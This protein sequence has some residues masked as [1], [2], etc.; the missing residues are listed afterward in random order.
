M[1][2]RWWM[3]VGLLCVGL[4]GCRKESPTAEAKDEHSEEKEA[5]VTVGVEAARRGNVVETVEGLGRSEAIPSKLAML[6]PAVEGHVHE[7]V[8]KQGETVKKGQPIVEF[9]QSAAL[10]DLAEK[11]ATRDGLKASLALL[12]VVPRPEERRSNELAVEQ[13]KVALE[14]AKAALER[15]RPL[16]T[17]REVSE[18]QVFEAELAVTSAQ[19]LEKT[20]E[21][22][23]H[24]MLIGPKP[25]AVAEA[26]AKI[27]VADGA[28]AFSKAHL[29]FHTIRAPID[30]VL[31]SLTCH[32]GQ[33]IAIGAPIGEVV[34]TRQVFVSVYLPARS[35]QA[36]K[37]GQ[38][39]QVG[40][41]ESRPE[42]SPG[43]AASGDA[44]LAGK[45]DFV[46]RLADA[47]TGNLPVLILVE[48]PDGRLTLGQ[49]MGVTI[50]VNEH[51]GVLE[52]PSAAILD[53]GEGPVLTV[54]RDGKTVALHPELGTAQGGWTAIAKTDL[55]EGE[56]VIVEG[57]YNL[58]AG[59]AVKTEE[60]AA[61]AEGKADKA[62][63]KDGKA[64][65]TEEK[66]GKAEGKADK[67]EGKVNKA[68]AKDG[69]AEGKVD[70]AEKNAGKAELE[71]RWSCTS[72]AFIP[73]WLCLFPSVASLRLFPFAK[74]GPHFS[75]PCEGGVGGVV[76]AQPVTV[77]SH[78]LFHS[79]LSHHSREPRRIVSLSEA[80]A[81]PPPPP[82]RKGGKGSD[83]SPPDRSKIQNPKSKIS[84][85]PP[86]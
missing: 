11:T 59:T 82:L 19:I 24:V 35:A 50:T 29:D 85:L 30:G 56:P 9:D 16:R 63:E 7:L 64:D 86:L 1:T 17:Q 73:I 77:A 12:K 84:A 20:A 8:V 27:A 4:A 83:R 78:V 34:D 31:D 28:V 46:G 3:I 66:D 25:E 62:E 76:P 38:K 68:E 39:A 41:V 55:K 43:E 71:K 52:V 45:V 79:V 74:Q 2:G 58:P 49:T 80:P 65:K 57:G 81:S 72:N 36:V 6:T 53:Q 40:I 15:L 5:H 32:P 44:G 18:Q 69:E 14:K 70:K 48:N 42:S 67:A 33:T 21:A 37:V 51:S 22:T 13:A 60:A 61:K 47:Q 54:V 75:P 10:A 23:L 26:E